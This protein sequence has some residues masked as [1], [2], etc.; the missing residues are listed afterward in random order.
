MRC[1]KKSWPLCSPD[2]PP[3]DLFLWGYVKCF[4]F[5]TSVDDSG[6][7]HARITKEIEKGGEKYVD[8]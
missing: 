7:I 1:G 2:V 8:P 4:V 6:T 5:M 3:L